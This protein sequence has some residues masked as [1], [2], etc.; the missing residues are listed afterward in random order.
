MRLAV[1]TSFRCDV[2]LSLVF[3]SREAFPS[4]LD[5]EN[6]REEPDKDLW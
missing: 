1:L 2:S 4:I 6:L 5:I 3:Y